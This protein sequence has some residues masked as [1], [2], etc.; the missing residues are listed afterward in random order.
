VDKPIDRATLE[1][2]L[3]AGGIDDQSY[4]RH[5]YA[6]LDAPV[7]AVGGNFDGVRGVAPK[8]KW[9]ASPMP[10]PLASVRP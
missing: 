4:I 3:D 8:V 1:L 10:R 5:A 6:A 2:R 9:Q 7:G